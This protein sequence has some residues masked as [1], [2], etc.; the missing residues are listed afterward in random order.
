[1]RNAKTQSSQGA[2]KFYLCVSAPL[3]FCVNKFC[4]IMIAVGTVVCV[5]L[6]GCGPP[7][8]VPKSVH[9]KQVQAAIVKAGGE[10]NILAESRT[11]LARLS[12][13][14]DFILDDLAGSKWCEGLNGITNLGDVFHYYPDRSDQVE[15]RIHN[16]HFDTYF[17]VLVN[18]DVQEP[19]GFERIAGNVGFAKYKSDNYSEMKNTEHPTLNNQYP[20]DVRRALDVRCSMFDVECF[21]NSLFPHA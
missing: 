8:P 11:L 5:A 15:I 10:T 17:I 13:Q 2:K 4:A 19:S 7:S 14:R 3:R 9:L 21:Q 18:P 12:G 1:M 20:M 16:S 6:S